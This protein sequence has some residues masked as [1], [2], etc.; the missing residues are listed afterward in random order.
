M[1]LI[2]E[3]GDAYLIR[4]IEDTGDTARTY[5][6][7]ISPD[8]D[9]PQECIYDTAVAALAIQR[10]YTGTKPVYVHSVELIKLA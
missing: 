10:Y 2:S 5:H 9:S 4:F 1:H 3:H 8:P 7:I 6:C